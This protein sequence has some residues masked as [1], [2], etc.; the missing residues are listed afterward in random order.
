MIDSNTRQ[1]TKIPLVLQSCLGV[2]D[3]GQVEILISVTHFSY[4]FTILYNES[5]LGTQAIHNIYYTY[6]WVYIT[7]ECTLR[8][9][10]HYVWVYITFECTLRLSVH[11]QYPF[12]RLLMGLYFTFLLFI[13]QDKTWQK[14]SK[15]NISN[16]LVDIV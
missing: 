11:M 1:S 6:V 7:F 2:F 10:V 14:M 15:S 16:F 12:I 8:L 13:M 3:A 9:S 5:I 4:F